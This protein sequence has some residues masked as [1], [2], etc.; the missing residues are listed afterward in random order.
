MIRA[1]IGIVDPMF[2]S[3]ETI[4]SSINFFGQGLHMRGLLKD[5]CPE[6]VPKKIPRRLWHRGLCLVTTLGVGYRWVKIRHVFE[7][8]HC[9]FNQHDTYGG[10][11]GVFLQVWPPPLDRCSMI[12]GGGSVGG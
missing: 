9:A 2:T 8:L 12:A 7:D 3:P 1:T 4:G 11:D 6:T 10:G 5:G